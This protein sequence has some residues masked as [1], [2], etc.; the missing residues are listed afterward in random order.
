MIEKVIQEI[1][2]YLK[3]NPPHLT[4]EQKSR[5]YKILNSD[6]PNFTAYGNKHSD[7]EK[8]IRELNSKFQL[9]YDEASDIFKILIKSDVHDEKIAG[10][11]LLNRFKKD[12][13]KETVDLIQKLIPNNFDSWAITDTTMIR[14]IGPFLGKKGNEELA[15]KVIVDWSTSDNLWVKRASLV[16]LLKIVMINKEFDE[17]YV[18]QFVEKMLGSPED[19]IQKGI[20]WLLKTC[21][22]YNP[23][24]IFNYLIDNKERLPRLILRYGS[25]KLPKEKR[26]QIL[27]K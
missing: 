22:K 13:N 27:K 23:D 20:G 2:A 19:Y 5:M 6:N 18:F 17:D 16:I 21:S 3:N 15:K 1:R 24:S 9:N 26:T 8:F 11:F 7:I 10:I 25:E 14:V 12:F 4:D